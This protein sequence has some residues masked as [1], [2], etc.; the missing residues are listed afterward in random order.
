M[1][2]FEEFFKEFKKQQNIMLY[3]LI[4]SMLLS[5]GLMYLFGD[6]ISKYISG[7]TVPDY[8][9]LYIFTII[10]I[11][12]CIIHFFLEKIK[13]LGFMFL[14]ST[15]ILLFSMSAAVLIF[16]DFNTIV[17]FAMT[18]VVFIFLVVILRFFKIVIDMSKEV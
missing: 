13:L 12:M 10:V 15:L 14:F 5:S 11:I 6:V 4:F 16:K 17:L 7:Y 3:L 2:D 1:K 8:I 9:H 18:F